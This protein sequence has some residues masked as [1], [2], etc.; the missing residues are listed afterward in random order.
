LAG[1]ILASIIIWYSALFKVSYTEYFAILFP[2][3]S[4]ENIMA[5]ARTNPTVVITPLFLDMGFIA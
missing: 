3:V 2:R 1:D 5:I 4:E